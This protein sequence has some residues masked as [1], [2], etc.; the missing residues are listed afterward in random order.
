VIG[1]TVVVERAP[2]RI[3]ELEQVLEHTLFIGASG[4][5]L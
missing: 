4:P 5:H 3:A 1:L 2:V